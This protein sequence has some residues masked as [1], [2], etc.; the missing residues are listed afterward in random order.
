M[1]QSLLDSKNETERARL[2]DEIIRMR[3]APLVRKILR[4]RLGFYL[5]LDGH[6]P[7]NPEAEDLSNEILLSLE[8][9]LRDLMAE[10]EK[11]PIDDY[12]QCVI[13]VATDACQ[14]FI[15][16]KSDPRVRLK[17]NLLGVIGRH[18]E[19]KVWKGND[20]LSLCGFATWEGRRISIA[21]SERLAWLKENP[22]SF[23]SKRFTYQSLQ[24]APYAKLI[25]EIFQW[26]G[27][28]IR[29]EDLVEL[30]PRFRQIN[31]QPAEPIEPAEK[32][33]ELQLAEP[34]S[35]S[36]DGPEKRLTTKQLWEEVKQ[37]PPKSRLVLCLSPVGEECEDLWDLLLTT[38]AVSLSEL[39]DGLEIPLEQIT[40]IWLEAPMDSKT[41]ADYLGTTTSQVNK[42]RF[43]AVK[44]LRERNV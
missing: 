22:E 24:K 39:A 1:V 44:Y 6:N 40:N 8:Q 16:A 26:L 4:Q 20:G 9:R 2:F 33:E 13:N 17:N 36:S 12:R 42:W 37:L 25:A 19:F 41:L 14:N 30:V 11:Y 34:A 28:P 5:N 27:D 21:A 38:D 35:P 3:T 10:P 29:F 43:Q 32:Q 18:S 23:K 31:D 7:N 15:R